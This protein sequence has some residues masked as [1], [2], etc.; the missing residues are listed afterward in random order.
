MFLNVKK[1]FLFHSEVLSVVE[2]LSVDLTVNNEWHD[3]KIE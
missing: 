2:S 3:R 1:I